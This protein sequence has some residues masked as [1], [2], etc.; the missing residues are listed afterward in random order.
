MRPVPQ[1]VKDDYIPY[2]N[3]EQVLQQGAPYPQVI[4]PQ[5]GGYWIED[6]EAPAITPNSW[7]SG[8]YYEEDGE[9]VNPGGEFGYR[10]ESNYAIRAYRKHFLGREHLNFYCTASNHGNLILSLR[11]E[12]TKDQEYL[13]IIL[14]TIYDRI[15][16]AGLTELPS[17]P[18]SAK[19]L[20][21]DIVGLRFSPVLYPRVSLHSI[22]FSICRLKIHYFDS[23]YLYIL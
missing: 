7:E 13:H 6:P 16:L 1:R 17:V 11:Q 10:L 12:E 18:Q 15:S 8:C 3:I 5:F 23:Y 20:C 19:L 9:G 4:L 22:E 21:E 14:R 2:P